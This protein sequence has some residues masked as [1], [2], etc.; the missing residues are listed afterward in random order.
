MNRLADFVAGRRT[1]WITVIVVLAGAMGLGMTQAGGFEGAQENESSS[2]LPG[3]AESVKA[4]KAVE[5]LP[6]GERAAAIVVYQREG[7]L[8]PEDEQKIAADRAKF[9]EEV[10]AG[11]ITE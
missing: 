9:N 7:G 6:G 4:L 2:F 10:E 8:T 3:D 11:R 5:E 1:K